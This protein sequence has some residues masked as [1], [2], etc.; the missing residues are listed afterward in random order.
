MGITVSLIYSWESLSP[1]YITSPFLCLDQLDNDVQSEN[2]TNNSTDVEEDSIS[3]SNSEAP[4]IN[5]LP[6]TSNINSQNDPVNDPVKIYSTDMCLERL[7]RIRELIYNIQDQ[8]VVTIH[9]IYEDMV[10]LEQKLEKISPNQGKH[11]L[12]EKQKCS[13]IPIYKKPRTEKIKKR[14]GEKKEKVQA[15]ANIVILD[16]TIKPKNSKKREEEVTEEI[17]FDDLANIV[18]SSDEECDDQVAPTE[19]FVET[20]LRSLLN[21]GDLLSIS[22]QQMLSDNVINVLQKM[23]KR[24]YHNTSGLQ[25]TVLGQT[26]SFDVIQNKPFVQILHNGNAHWLAISTFHCEPGHVNI[27]DSKCNKGRMT[28]D[29]K[30]QIAA[31]MFCQTS[32]IIANFIPVQQQTNGIDCGLY[33]IAFVQHILSTNQNPSKIHYDQ[34]K[35]RPHLLK[36][37]MANKLLPF[38]QMDGKCKQNPFKTM[39]IPLLCSCRQYWVQ[40]DERISIMKSAQCSKCKK[41]FHQT[42]ENIPDVAYKDENSAWFCAKCS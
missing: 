36:S 8:P 15:A 25:D 23:L 35:M 1:L 39:K 38:P 27:L 16:T 3:S 28:V 21:T 5:D 10:K 42:C 31:I 6:E 22:N 32:S 2:T 7:K 11:G 41:W 9:Q 29:T 34:S 18:I 13:N 30:K 14:V 24:Q 12:K 40:S 4:L 17:V 26:L 19:R 37:L 33:A 20:S